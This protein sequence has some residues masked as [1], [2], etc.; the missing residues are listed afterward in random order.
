MGSIFISANRLVNAQ[1]FRLESAFGNRLPQEGEM[2]RKVGEQVRIELSKHF[3]RGSWAQDE[4]EITEEDARL[5]C[6]RFRNAVSLD[7]QENKSILTAGGVSF[8]F[9]SLVYYVLGRSERDP[10]PLQIK[11]LLDICDIADTRPLPV[12]RWTEFVRS[13]VSDAARIRTVMRSCIYSKTRQ[14]ERFARVVASLKQHILKG[15]EN[16]RI[17][18]IGSSGTVVDALK[19]LRKLAQREGVQIDVSLTLPTPG[20]VLNRSDLGFD[21]VRVDEKDLPTDAAKVRFDLVIMGCGVIGKTTD[22]EIE[23]VNRG[24]D[25]DIANRMRQLG[26][27]LIIVGGLYKI[28][29]QSFYKS[30]KE[31]AVNITKQTMAGLEA[32]SILSECDIDW[33][34]TEHE[35]VCFREPG[36]PSWL[37]FLFGAH[38][39][40]VTTSLSL[41]ANEKSESEEAFIQTILR[42]EIIR[43]IDKTLGLLIGREHMAFNAFKFGL[44]LTIVGLTFWALFLVSNKMTLA[45]WA[46]A[47]AAVGAN[48]VMLG[49]L[50][51]RRGAA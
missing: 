16:I 46:S 36:R 32:T 1:Y 10:T 23:I 49:V 41:F 3:R 50:G 22:N 18:A 8:Y 34:V 9:S 12:M 20:I 44:V 5:L 29:P 28:W 7:V 2:N 51:G 45:F 19:G 14:E 25:I 35:A 42:N 37:E 17:L 21:F 47:I 31:I 11:T 6:E 13:N 4:S 30:H 24:R 39:L 40:D 26:A 43:D 48:I 15:K 33:L 27:L 38:S